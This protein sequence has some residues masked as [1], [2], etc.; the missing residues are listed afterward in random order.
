MYL[1]IKAYPNLLGHYFDENSRALVVEL[2]KQQ[3]DFAQYVYRLSV[4]NQAGLFFQYGLLWLLPYAG[5]MSI[6]LRPAFPMALISAS[7]VLGVVAYC[8]LLVACIVALLRR[9]D[10][11]G[12]AGL[13][14]LFPLVLFWTEFS[15]VWLQD[16]MVLYRSYLWA[17]PI[18]GLIALA[19]TGWSPKALYMTGAGLA[20]VLA[21]LTSERVL[22]MESKLS[23]WSDAIEKQGR[24]PSPAAVGRY[25]AYMNRGAYYLERFSPEMALRDFTVAL[26][27][28]EPNR[29]VLFNAGVAQQFLKRHAEALRSFE[30]AEAAGY[31]D[32]P[33]YFHRGESLF[34][35]EQF[36]RA[37]DSYGK[38][39]ALPQDSRVAR[40]TRVKRADSLLLLRRYADAVKEFEVA[41]QGAD[42]QAR[43]L[44][45]LGM[46][47]VGAKDNARAIE[48]FNKA[49]ELERNALAYYGRALAHAALGRS[50]DATKDLDVAIQLEPQNP[51]FQSLKRS[52]AKGVHAPSGSS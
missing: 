1:L 48:A 41:V 17:I 9:S 2:S 5:W 36:E 49:L 14:I 42:P 38:A 22:S 51:G 13:L 33:L 35:T 20:V 43:H 29:A 30:L 19:L 32:S 16:P 52:W 46:A 47:R 37:A 18:P 23:V 28:G 12:L 6:D 26:Q 4:M 45:G 34:A 50:E 8:S 40:E 3:P 7:T 27:L 31:R 15:A 21:A 39:L 25:R 24:D 10:A 44:I 11:M